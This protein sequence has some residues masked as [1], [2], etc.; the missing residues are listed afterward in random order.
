MSTRAAERTSSLE[1]AVG[2]HRPDRARALPD[3]AL[4]DSPEKT[5]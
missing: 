4:A 2:S 5:P 1:G 3:D